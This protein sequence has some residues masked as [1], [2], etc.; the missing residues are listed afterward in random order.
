M[1][2][3]KSPGSDGFTAEFFKVFWKKCL[4]VF[5]VRSINNAFSKGEMSNTQKEGIIICVPNGDKPREYLKNW[6]PIY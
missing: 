6:R 2:N 5:T 3:G 1:N 4:G